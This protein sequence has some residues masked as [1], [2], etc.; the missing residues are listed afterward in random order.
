MLNAFGGGCGICGYDKCNDS[1]E[2]HHLDPTE[3]EFTFAKIRSNIRGWDK[4]VIELRKCVLLCSNCHKEIHSTGC[5]TAIPDNIARFDEKYANYKELEEKDDTNICP[6]CT[7]E[8]LIHQITCSN[9]C[10][11]K[12]TGM[13]KWGEV[14]LSILLKEYGNYTRV[15]E[16]LNISPASVRRRANKLG[17]TSNWN[18]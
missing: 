2:F 13:V 7:G 15:G 4:I 6:V 8:K 17:L 1:L 18:K 12:R 11:A 14:N 5:E 10:A 16:V 9:T 3:K